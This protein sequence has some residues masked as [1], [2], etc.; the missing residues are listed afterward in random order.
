MHSS[1]PTSADQPASIRRAMLAVLGVAMLVCT[2]CA[3]PQAKGVPSLPFGPLFIGGWGLTTSDLVHSASE[4]GV[5]YALLYGPPPE[6]SSPQGQALLQANIRVISAEVSDHVS[7]YECSRTATVAPKPAGSPAESYCS[8][9]VEYSKSQLR[10]DVE[11]IA[12][13]D[14]TN[15][16]VAGYWILDD[17]PDWDY[18]SLKPVLNELKP[19]IPVDRPTICGFSAGLGPDGTDSWNPGRA[20]NFSA[21]ACDVVAPYV[22]ADSRN[23]TDLPLSGVDWAMTGLLPKIKASLSDNGWDQSRQPLLGVAQAF[24]GRRAKNGAI[25]DAPS[26]SDMAAQARGFCSMGA[27]GVAWFAW[28]ITT[29]YP[30]AQTPANNSALRDGVREGA[31]ACLR[32]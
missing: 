3:T 10:D 17:T 24:G 1:M 21:T 15:P 7:Q 22:Y 20:E 23:E 4:V 5:N 13:R 8:S 31:K 32:T 18:G 16:L 14:R 25:T 6:A 19:L 9:D 29:N 11:A 12:R 27:S 28:S 2:A 30:S 26:P